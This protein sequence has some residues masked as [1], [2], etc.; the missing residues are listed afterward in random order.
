MITAAL[1]DIPGVEFQDV[2]DPS[3]ECGIVLIM[4]LPNGGEAR[5][6]AEAVRAEGCPCGTMYS[7]E[8]PDRHIYAYW[9][10][11]LAKKGYSPK[12]NPWSHPH[13][14]GSAEYSKDMCPRSL[15]YLGR[16]VAMP[17]PD[18]LSEPEAD[19]RA[20]AFRKVASAFYGG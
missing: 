9:D 4:F 7:G 2:P 8:F 11:I 13:Y 10:H 17:I 18:H 16:A 20:A 6:Y 19:E 5:R 12:D 14:H 3:G 1:N 15:D